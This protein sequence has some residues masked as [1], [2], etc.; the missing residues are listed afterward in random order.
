MGA[1]ESKVQGEKGV[2]A[3]DSPLVKPPRDSTEIIAVLDEWL[4]DESGYD[5]RV[6]P[7]LKEALER[8]RPSSRSLFNG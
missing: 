1:A 5:E 7:E 4:S 2:S 3:D 6:W 8:N